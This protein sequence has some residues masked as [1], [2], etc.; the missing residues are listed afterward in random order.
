M[1]HLAQL[2]QSAQHPAA[3]RVRECGLTDAGHLFV[4]R[5]LPQG[6]TVAE[7]IEGRRDWD[8]PF[9]LAE[10]RSLMGPFAE[11]IDQF[12]SSN[13]AS[14]LTRTITPHEIVMPAG[15]NRTAVMRRVGPVIGGTRNPA[16]ANVRAFAKVVAAMLGSRV[17]EKI[18]AATSG[19]AGYLKGVLDSTNQQGG[20]PGAGT[21]TDAGAGV[22]GAGS[23]GAGTGPG[24]TGAGAAG[25]GA[26]GTGTTAAFAGATGAPRPQQKFPSTNP[27]VSRSRRARPAAR[28]ALRRVW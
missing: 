16:E 18:Y 6:R 21:G 27:W 19:A 3:A 8:S 17:D 22:A 15:N 1:A 28:C 7:L 5:D 9:T 23:A 2:A 13:K 24:A 11:A 25:A 12:N 20:S 4:V 10:T 14:F 26:V